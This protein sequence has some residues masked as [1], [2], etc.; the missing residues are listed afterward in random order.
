[1]YVCALMY[2]RTNVKSDCRCSNVYL[3]SILYHNVWIRGM[4]QRYGT[5]PSRRYG[6]GVW[7]GCGPGACSGPPILTCPLYMIFSVL[8][9]W[10]YRICQMNMIYYIYVVI[11]SAGNLLF[12]TYLHHANRHASPLEIHHVWEILSPKSHEW[13]HWSQKRLLYSLISINWYVYTDRLIDR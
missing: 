10:N 3:Y 4:E 6:T 5:D 11:W 1:M 9:I 7:N 8:H 13:Y 12:A 2:V